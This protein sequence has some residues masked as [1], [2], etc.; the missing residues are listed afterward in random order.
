MSEVISFRLN[1]DNPREAHA[2]EILDAWC[3]KGYS[4][5]YVITEALLKLNNPG[6][7]LMKSNT[8]YELNTTLERVKKVLEQFGNDGYVGV[9]EQCKNPAPSALADD[10]I[11][12]IRKVVKPGIKFD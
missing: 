3:S 5:R 9:S 6:L 8:F 7:D 1:K 12:S 4:M 11:T 10:F 2:L